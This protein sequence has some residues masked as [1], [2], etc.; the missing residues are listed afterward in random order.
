MTKYKIY[1]IVSTMFVFSKGFSQ[2]NTEKI[3]EIIPELDA[4]IQAFKAEQN[5]PSVAYGLVVDGK[6]IYKNTLRYD[7]QSFI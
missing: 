3:K 4:R 5:L 7:L 6:I 2:T 1:W